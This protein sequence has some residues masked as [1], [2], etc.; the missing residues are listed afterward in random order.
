MANGYRDPY[1]FLRQTMTGGMPMARPVQRAIQPAPMPPTLPAAPTA[2][3]V[4]GG[5][6]GR[7]MQAVPGGLAAARQ[8]AQQAR[9]AES[10]LMPETPSAPEAGL[11]GAF[12]PGTPSAAGLGAA[13]RELLRLGG[14]QRTPLSLGQI[15]GQAAGVGLEATKKR[16]QELAAA[17]AQKQQLEYE[18]MVDAFNRQVKL[19][20]LGLEQRRTETAAEKARVEALKP[21]PTRTFKTVENGRVVEKTLQQVPVTDDAGRVIGFKEQEVGKFNLPFEA[22]KEK[23]TTVLIDGVLHEQV[24]RFNTETGQFDNIG[25]PYPKYKPGDSKPGEIKGVI[26][27][28]G[29]YVSQAV[30]KN[31][32]IYKTVDGE[33]VEMQ[34]DEVFTKSSDWGQ[35]EV[36]SAKDFNNLK[37]EINRDK[38]AIDSLLDY[39]KNRATAEQ[40]L[41]LLADQFSGM[42]KTALGKGLTAKE[43][44]AA[45]ST[46]Q[47]NALIG[48]FRIETVGGGVMT[49]QDALRVISALGGDVSA[50]TNKQALMTQIK[51]ILESKHDSLISSVDSYNKQV[52]YY[53]GPKLGAEKIKIE[54]IDTSLIDAF[55]NPPAIPRGTVQ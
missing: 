47:L 2:G 44:A 18:R 20:E 43:L 10:L 55:L 12:A 14:P 27:K 21:G 19:R 13:G 40:G 35:K 36:L 23:T 28:D 37:T 42:I 5:G 38:G 50:L 30:E 15:L 53:Y 41:G 29:V 33:L 7:M 45:V 46:G 1:G 32:V 26:H 4:R 17:E 16:E 52:D 49:E 6:V 3:A 24:Q 25:E 54:D 22:P 8:R 11:L 34:P 39:A 48:R 51:R 31:G 9:A